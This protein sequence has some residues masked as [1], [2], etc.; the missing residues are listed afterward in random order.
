MELSINVVVQAVYRKKPFVACKVFRRKLIN[1]G[2][3]G[4]KRINDEGVGWT[5]WGNS[6]KERA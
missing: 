3:F 5:I 2:L 4:R 6:E 1:L